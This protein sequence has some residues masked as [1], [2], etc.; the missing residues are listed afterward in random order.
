MI[1]HGIIALCVLLLFW[2]RVSHAQTP[3]VI[4]VPHVNTTD[5]EDFEHRL[6]SELVA[7]GF[8]PI[9]VEVLVEVTPQT[10]QLQATR[11][12]S[13]AA[14]SISVHDKFV[15]GLVWIRA[16]G[17]SP[18]L[19]RSVPD[20][21]LSEQAPTVFAVRATDVL[22]GGLLELGYVGTTPAGALEGIPPTTSASPSAP[23]P[24]S[25]ASSRARTPNA[26]VDVSREQ[27]TSS[28]EKAARASA[29]GKPKREK[30][31]KVWFFRSAASLEVPFLES[32]TNLGFNSSVMR[33]LHTNWHVGLAGSVFLPAVGR[34]DQGR[35]SFTQSYVGVRL[36]CL[37]QLAKPLI[38][39]EFLETGAH[40]IFATGEAR[41]PNL[42]HS[43]QSFTGYSSIGLGAAWAVNGTV[44]VVVESGVLL[45]WRGADIV[46]ARTTVASAAGPAM[47][48]DGGVQL[49]F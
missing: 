40:A 21:P 8:Q 30:A 26:A 39:F 5:Y 20:Y 6:R 3:V 42:A 14:I 23:V 41:S 45:P 31:P 24:D 43:R 27:A 11:L 13:A 29:K 15:S 34:T 16:R 18:D 25:K 17:R 33:R 12:T 9:S 37:Q 48:F 47:L 1:R 7:E 2:A 35:V 38:L 28:N 32:P 49:G 44:G 19:L 10:L 4:V 22:H 36:D 46:V